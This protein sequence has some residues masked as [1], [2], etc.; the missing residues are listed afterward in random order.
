MNPKEKANDLVDSFI[1]RT[2][3]RN[4]KSISFDR[5]KKCALIA[6]NEIL[7]MLIGST[8][9]INYWQEVKQEIEKL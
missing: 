6:V 4:E 2:R 9:T 7:Y 1:Q 3:N 5:A 8:S